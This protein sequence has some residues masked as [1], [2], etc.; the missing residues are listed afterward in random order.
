MAT[1]AAATVM[2]L[3]GWGAQQQRWPMIY[4]ECGGARESIDWA[5]CSQLK[6]SNSQALSLD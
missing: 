5:T 4:I 6:L 2:T 3:F 1:A